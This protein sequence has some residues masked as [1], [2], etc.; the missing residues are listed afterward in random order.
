MAGVRT[1]DISLLSFFGLTQPNEQIT[2]YPAYLWS[3]FSYWM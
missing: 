1:E 3:T 2:F